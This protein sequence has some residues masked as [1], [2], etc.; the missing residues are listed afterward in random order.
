VLR[1]YLDSFWDDALAAFAKHVSSK[2]A[3]GKPS[4]GDRR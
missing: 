4:K 3:P 1:D 2:T